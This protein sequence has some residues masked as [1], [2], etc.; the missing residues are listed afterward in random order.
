MSDHYISESLEQ[1]NLPICEILT[2]LASITLKQD[3]GFYN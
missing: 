3:N 2:F 1:D